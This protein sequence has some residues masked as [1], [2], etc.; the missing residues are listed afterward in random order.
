MTRNPN[1]EQFLYLLKPH[2]IFLFESVD[3]LNMHSSF[4]N[5]ES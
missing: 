3:S 1:R 5:N 2:D 4:F